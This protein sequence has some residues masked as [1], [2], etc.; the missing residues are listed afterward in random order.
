MNLSIALWVRGKGQETAVG[1][2]YSCHCNLLAKTPYSPQDNRTSCPRT[3]LVREY[4]QETG[5]VVKGDTDSQHLLQLP[6]T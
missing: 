1:H 4:H 6:C 3:G 2:L 5:P